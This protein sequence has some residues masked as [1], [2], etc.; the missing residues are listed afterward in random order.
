MAEK[1][2]ARKPAKPYVD[3]RTGLRSHDGKPVHK[4]LR[5][6]AKRGLAPRKA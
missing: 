5:K 2:G 3:Y 1:I 4:P 6:G